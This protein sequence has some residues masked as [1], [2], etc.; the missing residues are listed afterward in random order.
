[1]ICVCLLSGQIKA[2]SAKFDT[3][4]VSILDRMSAIMGQLTS[5]SATVTT[6]Y[7]VSNEALGLVKHSNLHH[8]YIGGPDKMLIRSE[9]DKGNKSMLYNG[10]TLTHYSFDKNQYSRVK[11]PPTVVGMIDFMHTNYGIEFP[12]ADFFYPDFVEDILEQADHLVYIGMTK[13]DGKDCFHI[14]GTAKDK[15]F[16]FWIADDAFSLPVKM[17]IIYTD[18]PLNPQ[19]E[20]VYSNWQINPVLPSGMFDFTVPPNAQKV[21]MVSKIAKK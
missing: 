16:Q 15:T 4:A 9:G 11:V 10:K 14:A 3:V 21:K 7:D 1:M 6:S 20:A 2:Q 8:I 13:V 17:V 18:K 12:M 19:F 5:C